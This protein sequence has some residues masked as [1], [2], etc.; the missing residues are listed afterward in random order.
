MA[1]VN[2]FNIKKSLGFNAL[3]TA[4]LNPSVGEIY[5]STDGNLY[6]YNNGAWRKLAGGAT[7]FDVNQTAHGFAVLNG[8][9]HNGT[10]WVKA[11]ADADTTLSTHIVTE[12][13]DADNF[14]AANFGKYTVPAHGKTVG[15]H[16][17][18]SQLTAGDST[19][20]EPVSPDFSCP[21]FYVQDANTIHALCYRPSKV[22][23]DAYLGANKFSAVTTAGQTVFNLGFW[24]NLDA[25]NSFDF[26]YD[27]V[28]LREG[29]SYD[30]TL[31]NV[32]NNNSNQVTLTVAAT[33]GKNVQAVYRGIYAEISALPNPG[34]GTS[35]SVLR[36]N[37]TNP[38][39]NS[40][41]YIAADGKVGI[42]TT[43]P[44]ANLHLSVSGAENTIRQNAYGNFNT[45]YAYQSQ[46][47]LASPSATLLNNNLWSVQGFGYGATAFSSVVR[48]AITLTA[49]ENWTDVAQGT[50]IR[51][52]TTSGTTI[53][54]RMRIDSSGNVGIGTT[55]P[56][57]KLSINSANTST[58]SLIEMRQGDVIQGYIGMGS[59]NLCRVQT[60]GSQPI[61]LQV[62]GAGYIFLNT[63]NTERM[64]IDASGNVMIGTTTSS[65]N[66]DGSKFDGLTAYKP[67]KTMKTSTGVVNGL[68]FYQAGVYQGGLNFGDGAT[69]L[70]T[71]SDLRLK[72]NINDS[73]P[74]LDNILNIKIRDFEWIA[75]G[76]QVKYGFIAQEL[77]EVFPE[78]VTIGKDN[79]DGTIDMPWSISPT[80]LIPH[81]IK[82]I[83]ELSS[84][85]SAD[86]VTI[87]SLQSEVSS[88]QSDI[89]TLIARIEALENA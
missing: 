61:G 85:R 5:L 66:A 9:Y 44:L 43:S 40:S 11:L 83:Q 23:A 34:T 77:N 16:Y 37:G 52:L 35:G 12:V 27:G 28:L 49:T 1:S 26:F 13:I 69:S 64:R 88:L 59:D 87:S 79:E 25:K 75:Q 57:Q 29:A 51:F 38:E 33:V 62:N 7:A 56:G 86:A 50:A 76:N 2:G 41:V 21:L 36:L 18:L 15:E 68:L 78:A 63:S 60:T 71:S 53:G 10:T 47:T 65:D 74:V 46:G 6:Q 24:V 70:A 82:A 89:A 80:N 3:A 22:D 39:W 54:E 84:L 31:T 30:Y 20:S 81:M 8:I 58:N 4:P 32:V 55:S 42:G 67:L 73:A 72:T 14:V 48:A 45:L 17:F 19:I